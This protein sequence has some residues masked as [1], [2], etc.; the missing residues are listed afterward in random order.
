MLWIVIPYYVGAFLASRIPNTP[1]IIPTFVYEFG[2]LFVIL[3]VGAA[4]F[5]GKGVSVPFLSGVAI[6]SAVYLWLITNGGSLTFS[7][8]GTSIA[9]DFQLLVYL[10]IVP[11]IWAAIRWPLA[12]LVYRR[13]MREGADA[14]SPSTSI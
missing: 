9:L 13:S 5:D 12:Y 6:L 14:L 1:L 4:F 2:V 7:T 3:D 11:S 10:L 8:Q